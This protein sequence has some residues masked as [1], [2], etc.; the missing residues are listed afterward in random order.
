[1][2]TI[3]LLPLLIEMKKSLLIIRSDLVR[4][5]LLSKDSEKTAAS[6]F[7]ISGLESMVKTLDD[8]IITS[9]SSATLIVSEDLPSTKRTNHS[10]AAHAAMKSQRHGQTKTARSGELPL[11]CSSSDPLRTSRDTS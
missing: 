11:D 3:H 2:Q 1:M 4:S 7:A 8:H 9:R 10:T 5:Q 6:N